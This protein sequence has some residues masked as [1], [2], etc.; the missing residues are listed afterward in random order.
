ME[1]EKTYSIKLNQETHKK[2]KLYA[3]K[4]STTI[5]KQ[6]NHIIN[7]YISKNDYDYETT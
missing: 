6:V 7:E 5:V 3:V 4:N 2:L 1:T